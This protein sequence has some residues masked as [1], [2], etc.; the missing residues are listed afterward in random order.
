MNFDKTITETN[1][2]L[3]TEL[4]HKQVTVDLGGH[5]TAELAQSDSLVAHT[6]IGYSVNN[7]ALSSPVDK[8]KP[9]MWRI[10]NLT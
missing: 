2:T 9:V 10:A 8:T 4:T 1:C 6:L 7:K 5:K 3:Y